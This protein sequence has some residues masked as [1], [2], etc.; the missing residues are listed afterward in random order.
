MAWPFRRKKDV[1]GSDDP[2]AIYLGHYWNAEKQRAEGKLMYGGRRH[3]TG[4]GPTQVGKGA[5]LLIPNLLQITGKSI[6]VMDPKGQNAAVTAAWRRTVGDVL[7]LN[8]FD[9]LTD[10]YP[11]LKSAGWSA[12]ASL[13]PDAP[14]FYD[15]AAAVAEA[16]IRI[17][18]KD[19]HWSESGRG[20]TTAM[21]M[22]E[23]TLA[24]R[25]GRAPSLANV[26]AMLTEPDEYQRGPN[27]KPR[28][29]RGL[30]ITAARMCAEGGFVIESL[31][32]RFVRGTDE[33]AS[34]QSTTDTQLRWLLSQPMRADLLGDGIDFGRLKERP[35]TIYV[36]LPQEQ[37]ET[38]SAYLRLVVSA[39]LR[40]LY[41]PGGVP[42]LF[43]LDEFAHLGR[44]QPIE[45]ALG[46]AAGFGVQLKPVLQ[47]L[48]QLR[49]IYEESGWE[50][51]L[52]QSG[53]VLG[54]TPN[55]GF[56]ADWMS[57]RSGETTIRQPTVNTNQNPGGGV[58]SS[59]GE[60]Y[61]R[62]S[63]LMPQNLYGMGEGFGQVWC[64]G[65]P[66]P[67]PTYMPA[68]WEVDLWRRR[69]RPDPYHLGRT[70]QARKRS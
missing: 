12:L 52:G 25:E 60:G 19:P 64:A 59:A 58:G 5:R 67:I 63:Y 23:V 51:F 2:G 32:G 30:R 31:I 69:A 45:T 57:K 65:Q 16:L 20:L 6:V 11:D 68:Y 10:V 47:S 7:I 1:I 18:G 50:N 14:T 35:T 13:D 17:E 36:I 55:D 27:G 33:M 15:D 49:N 9:A 62:Q 46:L 40:A 29:V 42:V 24:R 61:G 26:R 39:A 56:S 41:K 21:V 37:M 70:A 38:H 53:A 34:I 4:F 54:F 28:L 43:M 66:R 44:L 3:L 48:T 22:W 8:P